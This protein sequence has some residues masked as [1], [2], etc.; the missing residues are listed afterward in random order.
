MSARVTSIHFLPSS[1]GGGH[2]CVFRESR[3][4][5]SP[6]GWNSGLYAKLGGVAILPAAVD[7][8]TKTVIERLRNDNG[9]IFILDNNVARYM[10]TEG[11]YWKYRHG[12]PVVATK[13]EIKAWSRQKP[14][15]ILSDS[16][17]LCFRVYR[18]I[19]ARYLPLSEQQCSPHVHAMVGLFRFKPER[20]FFM[21]ISEFSHNPPGGIAERDPSAR[22]SNAKF[23]ALMDTWGVTTDALV[24]AML[25]E[26]GAPQG[27]HTKAEMARAIA[28]A[29]QGGAEL[30]AL[31]FDKLVALN[32]TMLE[33]ID[34]LVQANAHQPVV[35]IILPRSEAELL[36]TTEGLYD[37]DSFGPLPVT[38]ATIRIANLAIGKRLQDAGIDVHF[39]FPS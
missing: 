31:M 36:A 23:S 15:T 25:R 6:D 10:E 27:D 20:P 18:R 22:P 17:D 38:A 39:C 33:L 11:R 14:E 24:D 3:T 30:P 29:R 8:W 28:E 19:R 12:Y 5:R 37:E 1:F 35:E 2:H 7:P 26:P 16:A 21:P 13:S 4:F 34:A 9:V 32:T